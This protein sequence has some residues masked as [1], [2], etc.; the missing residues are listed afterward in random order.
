MNTEN[1][2]RSVDIG[3]RSLLLAVTGGAF[4]VLVNPRQA[5]ANRLPPGQFFGAVYGG[6]QV[7]PGFWEDPQVTD[8]IMLISL[9]VAGKTR[10]TVNLFYAGFYNWRHA[11]RDALQRLVF[12]T[13]AGSI[14][15]S[16]K[17]GVPGTQIKASVGQTTRIP[18]FVAG[19]Q[20]N[21]PF[22]TGTPQPSFT[23]TFI[24]AT[25]LSMSFNKLNVTG[26]FPWKRIAANGTA[27][28]S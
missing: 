18:S 7:Y 23:A 6:K 12:V 5:A 13:A 20:E 11:R 17:L 9:A 8:A 10:D 15:C 28:I 1:Y 22:T 3:R 14:I 2:A 26:T 25:T 16:G 4:G 27:Q 24:T 21:G 19:W